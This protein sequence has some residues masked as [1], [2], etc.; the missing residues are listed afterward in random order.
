MLFNKIL[1]KIASCES[2]SKEVL[3]ECSNITSHVT[4]S[5]YSPR[6][7]EDC[8]KFYNQ[9]FTLKLVE[10]VLFCP[11]VLD[12][13]WPWWFIISNCHLVTDC[14][15]KIWSLYALESKQH[16]RTG[17]GGEGG[18]SPPPSPQIL[19][20]SDFLGSKRKF[21][22]SQFL[23]TFPCVFYYSKETNI[24]YFNLKKS[25]SQRNNPVTFSR[26]THSGCLARDEFLVI[27]KGIICW[28]T[29]L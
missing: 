3:F 24:F 4:L 11:T 23:K 6:N 21:G 29:Y 19:G 14:Y 15:E 25:W 17:R 5:L 2:T 18:C 20:D 1:K 7:W 26:D 8:V 27:G 22:Q 28:F 13:E 9:N 12:N 10:K 16:R